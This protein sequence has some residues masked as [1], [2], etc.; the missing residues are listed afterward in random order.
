MT[1]EPA[2][3]QFW[4]YLQSPPSSAEPLPRTET[5]PENWIQHFAAPGARVALCGLSLAG[6][7]QEDPARLLMVNFETCA[8]CEARR[9][10]LT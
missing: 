2:A 1:G 5:P 8:V 6:M 3:G 7:P 10:V 4:S 9:A